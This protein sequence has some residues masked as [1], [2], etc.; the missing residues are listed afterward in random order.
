MTIR[1]S[2]TITHDGVTARLLITDGIISK[3]CFDRCL[4]KWGIRKD[5]LLFPYSLKEDVLG[6]CY[7][8]EYLLFV[9][10][11]DGD[12]RVCMLNPAL[13]EELGLPWLVMS[14]TLQ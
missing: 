6:Y 12:V 8:G 14:P 13:S 7:K 2:L 10:Q 1:K 4:M 5:Q 3:R 11:A 9:E